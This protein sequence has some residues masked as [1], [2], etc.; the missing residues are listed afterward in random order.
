MPTSTSTSSS[1]PK[2]YTALADLPRQNGKVHREC[3][4]AVDIETTGQFPRSDF[5]DGAPHDII[6]AIGWAYAPEGDDVRRVTGN[7]CLRIDKARYETW[8]DVWVSRG[9]E[10]RC[11]DEFWSKNTDILEMLQDDRKIKLYESEKGMIIAFQRALKEADEIFKKVTIVTDTTTFDT[12]WLSRYLTSHGFYGLGYYQNTGQ[13]RGGCIDSSSYKRGVYRVN[14]SGKVDRYWE[15]DPTYLSIYENVHDHHPEHDATEILTDLLGCLA[16]AKKFNQ[17]HEALAAM[18]IQQQQQNSAVITKSDSPSSPRKA[19]SPRKRTSPNRSPNKTK[20]TEVFTRPSLHIE[21]NEFPSLVEK[22]R[23]PP[24]SPP[25]EEAMSCEE[26][27]AAA[28]A[29]GIKTA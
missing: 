21:P 1:S 3:F 17:Q 5:D 23:T 4:F 9:Y 7:A 14:P 10:K 15:Q 26:E 16:T 19:V 27:E 28:A 22:K 29:A 2:K 6:F 20:K 24:A 13:F 12:V 11:Y 8:R 18:F 25:Q